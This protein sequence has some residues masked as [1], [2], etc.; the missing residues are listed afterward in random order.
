MEA[1]VEHAT[2]STSGYFGLRF[3]GLEAV[4]FLVACLAIE[5]D[6]LAGA[7]LGAGLATFFAGDFV[8][9]LLVAFSAVFATGFAGG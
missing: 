6:F 2:R 7:F 4:G 8:G 1:G 5:G 9:V 3:A